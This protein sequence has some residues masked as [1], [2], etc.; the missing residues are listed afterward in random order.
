MNSDKTNGTVSVWVDVKDVKD[1]D[2]SREVEE[3]DNTRCPHQ[4]RKTKQTGNLPVNLCKPQVDAN[5][6]FLQSVGYRAF[7]FVSIWHFHRL[8]FSSKLVSV[9]SRPCRGL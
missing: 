5:S 7:G 6:K 4:H 8:K 9:R 2:K 1:Q 3:E